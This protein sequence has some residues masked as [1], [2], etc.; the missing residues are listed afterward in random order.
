ME[1]TRQELEKFMA[2][3]RDGEIPA[4]IGASTIVTMLLYR[5][6]KMA[7][8]IMPDHLGLCGTNAWSWNESITWTEL[9]HPS[10]TCV[11]LHGHELGQQ[12]AHTEFSKKS[13]AL[14][15]LPKILKLMLKL[16][17]KRVH[18]AR[19]LIRARADSPLNFLFRLLPDASRHHQNIR[20]YAPTRRRIHPVLAA[21]P[22]AH[23]FS[24][25]LSLLN[26]E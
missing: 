4:V 8:Y 24:H 11:V 10:I 3:V 14:T 6:I 1:N 20:E 12:C 2:T 22:I 21:S 25:I 5:A 19:Q 23:S 18:S 15:V 17:D 26:P 13:Q 16:R 9:L 7:G